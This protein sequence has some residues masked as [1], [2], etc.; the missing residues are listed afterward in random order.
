L[1]RAL[2]FDDAAH[3]LRGADELTSLLVGVHL[4]LQGPVVS[5]TTGAAGAGQ[6]SGL[7]PVGVQAEGT[8]AVAEAR[9]AMQTNVRHLARLAPFS[10]RINYLN[11]FFGGGVTTHLRVDHDQHRAPPA[12]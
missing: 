8:L 12:S 1:G 6:G 2:E 11:R 5:P 10:G 3:Q 9:S 4:L 7:T